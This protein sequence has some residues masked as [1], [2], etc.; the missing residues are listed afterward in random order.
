VFEAGPTHTG[1]KS[2]KQLVD[3]AVKSDADAIKFQMIDAD[4]LMV[5]DVDFDFTYLDER[6]DIKSKSASLKDIL[7]KRDMSDQDW[8]SLSNY[9]EEK[10]MPLIMTVLW[11]DQVEFCVEEL[12][13][14]GIK[15]CSGDINNFGL[16]KEA[17]MH[18]VEIHI[19]TGNCTMSEIARVFDYL[20]VNR[21][22]MVLHHCPSGYPTTNENVNLKLLRTLKQTF[23]CD[24]GFSDHSPSYIMDLAAIGFGVDVLEKT[25]TINKKTAMPEHIMSLEEDEAKSFVKAVRIIDEAVGSGIKTESQVNY[26]GRKVGRRSMVAKRQLSKGTK[27]FKDDVYF[28]RPEID[29]AVRPD[30]TDVAY[31]KL[32]TVTKNA[33]D[34]IYWSDL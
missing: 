34:V 4:R 31:E 23:G 29:G 9:C 14:S 19:D 2:A 22:D 16:I 32:L 10:S 15:L 11:E 3:I 20:D 5:K 12:R 13:C 21:D 8:L 30:Q 25:I 27:L 33:G 26:A 1:L 7:K 28:C 24:I 6:G 18:D 17:R